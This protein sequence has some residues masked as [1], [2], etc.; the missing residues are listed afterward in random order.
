M[1]TEQRGNWRHTGLFSQWMVT[2][3]LGMASERAVKL[4][5]KEGK[6]DTLTKTNILK[7]IKMSGNFQ[8]VQTKMSL[9]DITRRP[10]PGN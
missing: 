5:K 1:K 6:S 4:S 3:Y 10:P 9:Q 7:I 8:T 2:F